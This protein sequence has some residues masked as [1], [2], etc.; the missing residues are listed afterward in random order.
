MQEHAESLRWSSLG[1]NSWKHNTTQHT[2]SVCH[3][4]GECYEIDLRD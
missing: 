4:T 1:L 3:R 2:G